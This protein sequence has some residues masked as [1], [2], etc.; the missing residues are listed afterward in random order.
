MQS[1][2]FDSLFDTSKSLSD[3]LPLY[4]DRTECYQDYVSYIKDR[5]FSIG[6]AC[7]F[8][9]IETP[10]QKTFKAF[11]KFEYLETQAALLTVLISSL[12]GALAGSVFMSTQKLHFSTLHTAC[13]SCSRRIYGLRLLSKILQ[14]LFSTLLVISLLLLAG[15]VMFLF[16]QPQMMSLLFVLGILF[17]MVLTALC[18]L[19]IHQFE[20]IG[21]LGIMSKIAKK[22][23]ILKSVKFHKTTA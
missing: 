15:T 23:I 9:Q 2:K 14:G 8:C 4:N 20:K 3:F 5:F 1:A 17:L 19:L 22:P 10:I 21:L 11:W 12:I 6:N 13:L 7:D 16:F 18:G